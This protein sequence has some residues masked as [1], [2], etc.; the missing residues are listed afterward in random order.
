MYMENITNIRNFMSAARSVSRLKPIIALKSGRSKAGA[1]AA[2]SH[3]GAMAG[4]DEAYDAAFQR[5]GILRV[6]EFEELFDC[7]E[8]L[9]KQRRPP[10][11]GLTII[12]NA[13]GPGVMA[14][15]ALA[16]YGMEPARL[17]PETI[18]ALDQ[19]LPENWSRENP[20]DIL[21]GTS[22][23]AYIETTKICS[24]APETDALLLLCAPAGTMDT[25]DLGKNL[26]AYLKTVSCPVFTAWIGGDNVDRARQVFNEDGIVTYDSAERAVRAF[27]NLYQYG[28]NI[29]MLYQIPVRTD[30]RLVINRTT[31]QHIISQAICEGKQSLVEPQAK[32]LL[33]AYGIPANF[34]KIADSAEMAVQISEQTGFPVVLKICSPDI[35]HKSDCDGVVLD[36]RSPEQVKE[37]YGQIL[38]NARAFSPEADIKGV[39]VQAMHQSADYELIIGTR[40][41]EYFGPLILFGMGGVLTEVFQDT[42]MGL[43]PLNRS[44]ARHMIEQTKISKAFKGFRHFSTVNVAELEELLIR[45]GRLVTDFPEI[46][47][48]DI[49]PLMVK[50]GTITAVDARVFVAPAVKPSPAHLII[51][52][53]PWQYESR[54]TTVDGH[55]FFVRPIRPS[56]ADLLIAHFSSLSPRSIY[57]RFFSPLKQLSKETLIR[58]TQIDYD[59]EI[60][61]VAVMGN[62]RGEKIVGVSRIIAYPDGTHAEFALATSDDWQGKGIGASLLKQCLKAARDKGMKNVMG[63]VLAENTQM[64]KL[65]KK[66]GFAIS[67]VSGGS[68][69]ELTIEY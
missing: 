2:A 15:D 36:I 45:I 14:V 57:M 65:G 40:T 32:E 68:E 27:K 48:L 49:N 33:R 4:E 25:L 11:P 58:L 34:T 5:A 59:R 54:D 19:V 42:A 38:K 41:D 28:L 67:R 3:T 69:Y 64:L 10:G 60:A 20:I 51:S 47:S 37:A 8:F 9:A 24:K 39:S 13:G 44:L 7:L 56:D 52:S 66:L 31:A 55:E 17:G 12:S 30:T 61:L 23:E 6:N 16:G 22:P 35:V 53:Y 26:S 43:P 62:G 46:T 63:L 18:E 1:R 50:D 21:G 29:E